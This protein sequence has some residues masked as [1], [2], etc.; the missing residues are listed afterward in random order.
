MPLP[1]IAGIPLLA[2]V[3]GGLFSSVFS[4][5]AQYFT[6]RIAL[7][8][9]GL[10]LMAGIVSAFYAAIIALITSIAVT[11]PQEIIDAM[12]FFV[13]DNAVA[14]VTAVWTAKTLRYAYDWNI[15]T[16]QLKFSF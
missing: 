14:V 11:M 13:P 16:V 1:V 7:V 12:G 4:F 9:T 3:L 15:K 2:G 5:A 8:V 6:K 10:V